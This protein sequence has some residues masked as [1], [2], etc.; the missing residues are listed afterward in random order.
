MP[1]LR[2]HIITTLRK[3]VCEDSSGQVVILSS[4]L[5]AAGKSICHPRLV[6]ENKD[7]EG[8]S[9]APGPIRTGDPLLRRCDRVLADAWPVLFFCDLRIWCCTAFGTVSVR[10]APKVAP[11][12]VFKNSWGSEMQGKSCST[13]EPGMEAGES[14]F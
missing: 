10:S 4:V 9:G 12:I 5:V 11:T 1:R 6:S 8:V 2:D 13:L 3:S 7:R 14:E